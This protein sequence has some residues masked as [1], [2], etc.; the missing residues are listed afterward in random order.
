MSEY[1]A[2]S[3][4]ITPEQS[5]GRD[6][7]EVCRLPLS[8]LWMSRGVLA[9]CFT[10]QALCSK[11]Q[12]NSLHHIIFAELLFAKWYVY[13]ISGVGSERS[14]HDQS[15]MRCLCHSQRCRKYHWCEPFRMTTDIAVSYA[16]RVPTSPEAQGPVKRRCNTCR[17]IRY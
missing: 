6:I 15:A 16:F 12:P 5:H 4:L 3:T 8:P 9:V 14:L 2:S 1:F 13:T 11:V 17:T 7:Y 10:S